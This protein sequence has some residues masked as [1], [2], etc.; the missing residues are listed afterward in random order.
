MCLEKILRPGGVLL[1]LP[2]RHFNA[3]RIRKSIGKETTL[4]EDINDKEEIISI[5]EQI[6]LKL[7]NL[8]KERNIKGKTVTLKVK[9]HDFKSITRSVTVEEPVKEADE[10]MNYVNWL[11]DRTKAGRK[12]VRLLGI[13]ISNFTKNDYKNRKWIQLLLPF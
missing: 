1:G 9:Y 10:I 5:L 3:H 7:E 4:S 6:A 13:T 11:L 12:K 2:K 8:L